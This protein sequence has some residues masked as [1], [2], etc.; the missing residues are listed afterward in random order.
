MY[1]EVKKGL[2]K[3]LNQVKDIEIVFEKDEDTK[4]LSE[5]FYIS[6]KP[7]EIETESINLESKLYFVDIAYIK[8]IFNSTEYM[9][10]GEKIDRALRPNIPCKTFNINVLEANIKIS[11]SILHYSFSFKSTYVLKEKES[12]I[13]LMENLEIKKVTE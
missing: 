8:D 12:D 1:D 3:A 4:Q 7:L 11:D 5:Y 6:I 10:L 9:M 13:L 2:I